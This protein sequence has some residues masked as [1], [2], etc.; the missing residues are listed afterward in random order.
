MIKCEHCFC[1]DMRVDGKP[2]KGCCMCGTRIL[3]NPNW[4]RCG[5]GGTT[6][7]DWLKDASVYSHPTR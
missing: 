5:T 3:G 2:H 4:I 7:A 1:K 6:M